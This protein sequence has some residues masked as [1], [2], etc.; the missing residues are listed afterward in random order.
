M[1]AAPEG[2]SR[3]KKPVISLQYREE[4]KGV[5]RSKGISKQT[6]KRDDFAFAIRFPLNEKEIAAAGR[7]T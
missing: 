6:K 2:E 5:E 1:T 4:T 3:Q 7:L